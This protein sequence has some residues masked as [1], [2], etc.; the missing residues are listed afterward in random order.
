M[1]LSKMVV[2]LVALFF[3]STGFSCAATTTVPVN[4]TVA[5]GGYTIVVLGG[6][7]IEFGTVTL[8]GDDQT[9]SPT[10]V[11][12]LRII[13]ATGS[14]AG[15]NVTF[16]VTD[17]I[18]GSNTIPKANLSFNPSGGSITRVSG[19][20]IDG[21]NGPKETGGGSQALSTPVKVVTTNAGYG[22]GRYDYL[23][24]PSSFSLMVP[25]TVLVGT[26]ASTLTAT[27][28]SGP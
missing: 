18:S 27:L 21:S 11:A 26:Y 25:A 10:S 16:V 3:M 5:S 22:K 23:A 4:V 13:D 19:Q 8:N 12:T 6:G 20:T 7:T 2:F 17:F 14:N 1:R 28:S 15:W 24:A 9:V